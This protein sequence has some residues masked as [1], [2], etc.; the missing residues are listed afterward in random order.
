MK[1]PVPEKAGNFLN[2][3]RYIGFEDTLYS[4]YWKQQHK[5]RAQRQF[6][7]VSIPTCNTTTLFFPVYSIS[8]ILYTSR[9]SR[10]CY[11]PRP[12]LI[13]S[14]QS[15]VIKIRNTCIHRKSASYP[16]STTRSIPVSEQT[17]IIFLTALTGWPFQTRCFLFT[18][19]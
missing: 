13:L 18:A 15:A 10:A 16:Q 9:F 19:H 11:M 7:D 6:Q 8:S 5:R 3:W 1:H 12:F 2:S 17:A 14:L 4:T